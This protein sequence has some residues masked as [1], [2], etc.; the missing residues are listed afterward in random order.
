MCDIFALLNTNN[1][2][3]SQNITINEQFD[4]GRRRGPEYSKLEYNYMKM[5]LGFHRLA[6]TL[7]ENKNET[8][9]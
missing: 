6:I 2:D 8:K 7:T 4:K 1:N 5:I 9:I 3:N